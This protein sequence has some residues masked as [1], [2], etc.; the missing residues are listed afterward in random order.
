MASPPG[1]PLS[2]SSTF[3]RT[4][5]SLTAPSPRPSE[6][7]LHKLRE[8]LEK[9][10]PLVGLEQRMQQKLE[11]VENVIALRLTRMENTLANLKVAS[12]KSIGKQR[13][14]SLSDCAAIVKKSSSWGADDDEDEGDRRSMRLSREST[15][16]LTCEP[17]ASKSDAGETSGDTL[18]E[19]SE[20]SEENDSFSVDR[21]RPF[22]KIRALVEADSQIRSQLKDLRS[23]IKGHHY[24]GH[25]HH[26]SSALGRSTTRAYTIPLP[27]ILSKQLTTSLRRRGISRD[28]TEDADADADDAVLAAPSAAGVTPQTSRRQGVY[29]RGSTFLCGP[30][31]HPDGRF[32]SFWNIA[33]ALLICFGGV[34]IPLE[35]AFDTDMR[36]AMCGRLATDGGLEC[37]AHQVWESFNFF[38][39]FWFLIDILINCRTGYLRDGHFVNED[40]KALRHYLRGWF[41]LDFIGSFPINFILQ[42]SSA[43]CTGEECALDRANRTLRM[44]RLF[45]LVKLTRM[46][47]L[48]RYLEDVE[49]VVKFNPA[50]LRVFRLCIW[51]IIACHWFGCIWWLVADWEMT[52][53]DGI[54]I[55]ST[56]KPIYVEGVLHWEAGENLW[57]PPAWLKNSPAFGVKF[58]HAFY[59]GA[60]IAFAMTPF[61]IM[62]VTALETLVTTF[63]MCGGLLLNAFVISSF[64]SAFAEMDS[65]HQL[66]GKQLDMIRNYLLLKAVPGDL[67]SRI[68]EYFQYIYTSSQSMDHLGQLEHMP[69]NLSTQLAL[70]VNAKLVARCS[71]FSNITNTALVSIVTKLEPQVFVPGQ[72]L[73]I[74]GHLLTTVYFIN[75]GRVHLLRHMG[76][77]TEVEDKL[78][79]LIGTLYEGENLGLEE[80]LGLSAAGCR[81][82]SPSN[83]S[84]HA[85]PSAPS[86]LVGDRRMHKSARALTYCDVMQLSL[87]DLSTA[88]EHDASERQQELKLA[89]KLAAETKSKQQDVA[90]RFRKATNL[91]SL[92]GRGLGGSKT[93]TSP[94]PPPV[95]R[96]PS[97]PAALSSGGSDSS[98]APCDRIRSVFAN[99]LLRNISSG[100]T[101]QS[102]ARQSRSRRD[103]DDRSVGGADVAAS[104]SPAGPESS[105]SDGNAGEVRSNGSDAVTREASE[106]WKAV[107]RHVKTAVPAR[108]CRFADVV[109]DAAKTST[110]KAS[111]SAEGAAPPASVELQDL[112]SMPVTRRTEVVPA[113]RAPVAAQ[114]P[115][116]PQTPPVPQ[117][118][119]HSPATPASAAPAG[120]ESSEDSP[121]A[122]VA[123]PSASA[124]AVTAR[125]SRQP[126]M[127]AV[128]DT[129]GSGDSAPAEAPAAVSSYASRRGARRGGDT[130]GVRRMNS[131]S[132]K[133]PR[134]NPGLTPEQ[135]ADLKAAEGR[136]RESLASTTYA[137]PDADDDVYQAEEVE[138]AI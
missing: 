72:A 27:A 115:S 14:H 78:G 18:R 76:D 114:S 10:L 103:S 99:S 61:D 125:P 117:Q 116:Q 120:S 28:G 77:E 109:S 105:A 136:V 135:S 80:Y 123:R 5:S 91:A 59:W 37:A 84:E 101:P 124:S 53:A 46:L 6:S 29:A 48:T 65:K 64:T 22:H 52:P 1:R 106:G 67:R 121:P 104:P 15:A 133:I 102:S 82:P 35:I 108:R 56:G 33:M 83:D 70:S 66:A 86:V 51:M 89:A 98:V 73:C 60:G 30:V 32:R 34:A 31:L 45:K 95:D 49:Q 43:G 26:H 138:L 134:Q 47:K 44:L 54:N 90:S 111:T 122:L 137:T 50:V 129:V 39:D 21:A 13:H 130:R 112:D 25:H 127:D 42:I 74:E 63:L 126:S 57:L 85:G 9:L 17:S 68:L 12:S 41:C 128:A 87:H 20:N 132:R 58:C 119:V 2:R 23:A 94:S 75:R 69:P 3:S 36:L 113:S 7:E 79:T 93:P 4:F 107:A 92:L 100:S 71:F 97:P 19:T 81:S 118:S 96:G 55:D 38:V 110:T 62:P 88:L 16:S 8:S 24:N 131:D 40:L 11:S